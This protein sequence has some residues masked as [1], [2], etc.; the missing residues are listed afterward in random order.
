MQHLIAGLTLFLTVLAVPFSSHASTDTVLVGQQTLKLPVLKGFVADSPGS[1][2]FIEGERWTV[3]ANRLVSQ[4]TPLVNGE[5]ANPAFMRR[6]VVQVFRKA[7]NATVSAAEFK[8]VK[9]MY[10]ASNQALMKV[11]EK[12]AGKF[13]PADRE[14]LDEASRSIKLEEMKALE[15]F[16][17]EAER[18]ISILMLM[19]MK[20]VLDDK[21]VEVPV[22]MSNSIFLVKGKLCFLY[23]YSAL[24]APD[25]VNWIKSRTR[26]WLAAVEA[27]NR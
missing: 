24:D 11:A 19:K 18:S 1:A 4:Y 2:T 10:R 26:E 8:Q 22:L 14:S 23:V 13:E 12:E 7:E 6:V 16:G 21:P 25:S 20:I 9:Q 15:T 27:N 5:D 3:P 17:D